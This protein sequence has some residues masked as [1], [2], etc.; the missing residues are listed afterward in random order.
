MTEEVVSD[1]QEIFA[2]LNITNV[3]IA[4]LENM[5]KIVIPTSVFLNTVKEDRELQVDYNSDDQT[6]VFTLKSK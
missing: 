4:V 2:S 6:F 3:L 1:P 5:G